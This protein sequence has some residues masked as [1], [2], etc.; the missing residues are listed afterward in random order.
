MSRRRLALVA[1]VLAAAAPLAGC[2]NKE[3]EIKSA[4]TEGAYLDVGQLRYQIEISRELNP[5]DVEDR[6]YLEGLPRAAALLRPGQTWFAVFVRVEN[7][8][9]TP[10]PAAVDFRLGDTQDNVYRPVPLPRANPFA[11]LGGRVPGKGTLPPAGSVAQLNESVNGGLVLFKIKTASF[12]NRP[13]ELKI[14]GPSVPQDEA[15]VELDV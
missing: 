5:A 4:E 3:E 2:G 7:D 8:T 15:T 11:Y 14:L 10:Q 12:E 1:S 13:L 6:D 9:D